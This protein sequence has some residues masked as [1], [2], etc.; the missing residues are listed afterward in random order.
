MSTDFAHNPRNQSNCSVPERSSYACIVGIREV[1]HVEFSSICEN[2]TH[3]Q[4]NCLV[5]TVTYSAVG[6]HKHQQNN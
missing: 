2:Y 1:F 4:T 5:R 3:K 6:L